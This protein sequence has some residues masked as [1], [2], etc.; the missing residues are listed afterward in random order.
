MDGLMLRLLQ[1]SLR[2]ALLILLAALLRRLCLRILPKGLLR[3]L[4]VPALLTLL[5]PLPRPFSLSL[6]LPRSWQA[7][8]ILEA[9]EPEVRLGAGAGET[10]EEGMAGADAAPLPA[11]VGGAVRRLPI[12]ALIWLGGAALAGLASLLLYLGEYARFRKALPL[13]SARARAWLRGHPVRRGLALRVLPGLRGPMTYGVLRP[14]ILLPESPD[15]GSAPALMALE[16]EYAHVRHGDAAWKLLLHLALVL[17]WFNPAVWLMY[18]LLSRDLELGCDE[19]VLLRLGA[20]RRRDFARLLLETGREARPTLFP[21]LGAGVLRERIG[22]V[23][24]FR[25]AGLLRRGLAWLLM[26]GLSLCALCSFRAGAADLRFY[27]SG[28]LTL[29]VPREVDDL[30]YIEAPEL[31]GEAEEVLFRIWERESMEAARE[32]YPGSR[33]K[34]GLLLTLVRTDEETAGRY[35]RWTDGL[36]EL[37]ARDDR[38]HYYLAKHTAREGNMLTPSEETDMAGRWARRKLVNAWVRSL[39]EHL[40]WTGSILTY[41][42]AY[43]TAASGFFSAAMYTSH[44]RFHIALGEGEPVL[45][46]GFAGAEDFL[47]R[48]TW[49]TGTESARGTACPA[50]EPIIV[51]RPTRDRAL[52]FWPGSDLMLIRSDI[53]AADNVR[54]LYRVSLLDAPGEKAGD[55]LLR[56][57]E[58][59]ERAAQN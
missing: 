52:Y 34:W 7:A 24:R 29:A 44:R 27:R 4:W 15:W 9:R 47:E 25:R 17:H 5:L 3:L 13:R 1:M 2:G 11:D 58:A 14:V 57:Y 21:G 48:L 19:A 53:G 36:Q 41:Y 56:W 22:A 59:A 33:Q 6:P 10:A 26:L 38:G 46:T 30:L 16:H 50:G 42:P 12:P 31:T 8:P 32:L 28:G 18:P 20:E 51:T 35:L 43:G 39:R 40:S 49:E 45:L 23:L 37:L 54:Y 55:L